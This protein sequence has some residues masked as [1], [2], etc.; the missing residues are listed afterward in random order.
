MATIPKLALIPS[1]Y[2]TS[3]IYSVIPSNGAGDFDFARFTIATRVNKNNL[4]ETVAAN[5]PRLDYTNSTC[6]SLLLEPQST[7]KC[8][9]S[10]YFQYAPYSGAWSTVGLTR[11]ASFSTAPDAD[12]ATTSTKLTRT[13]L[14]STSKLEAYVSMTG[15]YTTETNT[16]SIYVKNIDSTHFLFR[17][18]MSASSS[19]YVDA[20]FD[21][22]TKQLT[23]QSFSSYTL[24]G[25]KVDEL[26]DGWF[27]LSMTYQNSGYNQD[28]F[29]IAPSNSAN[30]NSVTAN[31][32]V[33]IWGAQFELLDYASA[34]MSTY[35]NNVTRSAETANGAGD[36]STFN[37]SEGVLMA[38][39]SALVDG[40][41]T[42]IISIVPAT[43][44]ANRIIIYYSSSEGKIIGRVDSAGTP[45]FNYTA[46][47][48]NQTDF[49]KIALKYKQNDFAL[50]INGIE[51]AVDNT[52]NTPSGLNKLSFDDGLNGSL[53][54]GNVK[55]IQY[56]DSAL[57][58]AELQELTTI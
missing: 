15:G 30:R 45:V 12:G 50:W 7:N 9:F 5:I 26:A 55:Q 22:A 17:M 37:D 49:N 1:G 31:T 34:Y 32:S 3:N 46:T 33:E 39:I 38:E 44:T 21:F 24:K 4:V 10:E 53:F 23:L 16:A 28:K 11:T 35:N 48:N 8:R 58:D 41:G 43:G 25:L 47:V 13:S 6:P 18:E 36:A 20:S 51:L 42:R 2:K 14:T 40:V 19:N 56:F 27:R 52:G 54:Y 29:Q 57:T